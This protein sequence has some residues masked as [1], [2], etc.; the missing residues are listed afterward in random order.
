VGRIVFKIVW[1]PD[2]PPDSGGCTG[3]VVGI[4]D[5][6]VV[7]DCWEALYYAL[8]E[9]IHHHISKI[10]EEAGLPYQAY[11]TDEIE[12]TYEQVSQEEFGP[13]FDETW[14]EE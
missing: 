9:H 6:E 4:P 10:R 5:S 14:D 8:I 3:K 13:L 11:L 1:Y 2:P 12:L 7:A